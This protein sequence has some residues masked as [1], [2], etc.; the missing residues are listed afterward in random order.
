MSSHSDAELAVASF[1]L[2]G[3]PRDSC[4]QGSRR[5]I[6]A[7]KPVD[8]LVYATSVRDVK[9]EPPP[10]GSVLSADTYRAGE[11]TLTKVYF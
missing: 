4:R 3:S 8:S 5:A 11:I 7:C 6:T 2:R 10:V 9:W 1:T